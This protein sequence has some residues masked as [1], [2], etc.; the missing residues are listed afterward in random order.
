MTSNV[1][2]DIDIEKNP[3][4]TG[5]LGSCLRP[6]GDDAPNWSGPAP[7]EKNNLMNEF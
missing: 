4:L 6:L 2:G 3:K 5:S 7:A 1:D